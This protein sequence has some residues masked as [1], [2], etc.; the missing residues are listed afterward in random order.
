[1]VVDRSRSTP[2]ETAA[3]TP[4]RLISTPSGVVNLAVGA[5]K[6]A[7]I[8]LST[9]LHP[10][11]VSA[12]LHV[13]RATDASRKG[14]ATPTFNFVNPIVP[15]PAVVAALKAP[16]WEYALVVLGHFWGFLGVLALCP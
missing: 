6:P 15:R 10:R 2:C 8:F 4:L 9:K 12:I 11:N 14:V 1:M 5:K 3:T 13:R 16:R 7:L